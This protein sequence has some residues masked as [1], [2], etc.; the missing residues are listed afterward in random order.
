MNKKWIS[1]IVVMALLSWQVAA[2]AQW[3]NSLK[4]AGKP[5]A[6]LEVVREGKAL[7]SIQSPTS[8]TPQEK[9]A[10]GELQHWIQ[11]MTGA[12][13]A[14][15]TQP[16]GNLIKIQTDKG[17]GEEGYRIAVEGKDLVLS[18]GTTRGPV[19]AVYALL[20]EDLG[21]RFYTDDSIRLPRSTTLVISPVARSYIPQLRLRDPFYKTAFDATWSIRNRTNAPDAKVPENFGGHIDYDDTFVHTA[22]MLLPPDKYFKTHPEYFALGED[23]KRNTVQ[24]CPTNP[25]VIRIV[26]NNV[27]AILKKNPHTEII[28]VSK[29]DS[30]A[31]CHC[32]RCTKLREAEGSDMAVQLYLVNRVA[33]AVEKQYPNVVIDTL[34]YLDTIQVPRTVRPR[35]NV[36]IRL[37]NDAVGAWAHPFTPARDCDIA[38]LIN[39]W[40]AVHNRIY[41]W[42]YNVNFSH[43]LAPMPNLDVMADNV[44]FWIANHAEGV[45]LQGDYQGVGER[46]QLKSWVMSKILWDPSRDL[47]ALVQDFI[48]GHYGQA[49]PAM[50]EYEALLENA[51][52]EHAKDLASPPGGIRYP[53]DVSFLNRDFLDKATN[54]FARAKDLAQGDPVLVKRIERAELPILYVQCVRGPEFVGPAYANVVADF[55]RIGRREHV[56]YLQEGGPDFEANL[57]GFKKLAAKA[58]SATKPVTANPG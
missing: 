9:S 50:A 8:A 16:T 21:C 42:D 26:T 45:M 30:P 19:N 2:R 15:A 22:A 43:Y 25:D 7:Y 37:C 6:D 38:K 53:M 57:A 27:L 18:G 36:V 14:I 29:N 24:L 1:A 35:K 33:A 28:S 52:K 39:A 12:K 58:S 11:Q 20:E 13:L 47:D 55:E 54:I 17:L 46:D 4:P 49:A 5:A 34:A 23:G 48:W 32:D 40:S 51:G 44:R 31:E 56:K 41:I 10:A 3:H